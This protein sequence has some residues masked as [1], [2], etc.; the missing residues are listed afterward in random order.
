[1][2]ED[3][4]SVIVTSAPPAPEP[5]AETIESEPDK[6]IP[7][8][9]IVYTYHD[10]V[11]ELRDTYVSGILLNM[12][13]EKWKAAGWKT[14]VLT[15]AD[16]EKHEDWLAFS[17]AVHR[18][19]T[20]NP[21]AYEN[22]CYHRYLAMAVALRQHPGTYGILADAD[23]LPTPN[24]VDWMPVHESGVLN[25]HSVDL[26]EGF[27]LCPCFMTG[28]I[29]DFEGAAAY[30]ANAA[31]WFCGHHASDQT[32][33]RLNRI[34]VAL[35]RSVRTHGDPLCSTSAAIHYKTDALGSYKGA[36]HTRIQRAIEVDT[37]LHFQ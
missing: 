33:L 31:D 16:A 25:V 28:A 29:G 21:K 2:T 24:A 23:V 15:K 26:F 17:A 35:K 11:P 22:A 32:L 5:T 13:E 6:G 27:Q 1:M 12:F 30:F 37:A 18:L 34:T 4:E 3:I 10:E 7:V 36:K 19:P 8:D 14:R 9:R 20:R